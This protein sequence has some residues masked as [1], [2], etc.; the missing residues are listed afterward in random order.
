MPG[1]YDPLWL[2][3]LGI[4]PV[5]RWLHR[6][7]APLSAWPV[8]AIFLWQH[9]TQEDAPGRTKKPP[10]AV[11]R[12]R[13]LVVALLIAALANPYWKAE[14]GLLTVWV[15]DSLSMQAVENGRTRLATLLASLEGELDESGATWAEIELR[16]LSDPGR[17]RSMSGS[18]VAD[19]GDWQTG[20]LLEP[21]GP[22]GPLMSDAGSHWLLTDGASEGV[23]SWARRV[24]IERLLQTGS[25]TENSAVSHLAARRSLAIATD[26]DVLVS[27][28][29]SGLQ[30]DARRVALYSGGQLLNFSDLSLP[31]GETV[32]WQAQVAAGELPLSA[33]LSPGDVLRRDDELTLSLE[34][35]VPLA[36]VV[37]ASCGPALRRAIA[38][39]PSLRI[40]REEARPALSVSCPGDIFPAAVATAP[41][42]ARAHVRALIASPQTAVTTPVWTPYSGG[43]SNLALAGTWL[44]AAHLVEQW[45]DRA[46]GARDRILLDSADMPLVL[47]RDPG[48]G[49]AFS[50]DAVR[51]V[52]TVVDLREPL[53]ARQ[54]EY[55]A[56][57]G[58]LVDLST[59]RQLLEE[60]VSVSRD[61]RASQ[62]MPVTIDTHGSRAETQRRAADVPLSFMFILAALLLLALDTGLYAR[63]RRAAKH[64]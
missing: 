61:P 25:A 14:S 19:P 53:F 28:S 57:V 18:V 41:N 46:T 2:A 54:P 48:A 1:F 44:S 24:S 5:I 51:F 52:D 37:E 4:I 12:R 56:F 42:S 40:H 35:F 23:Q 49:P 29:N 33:R 22:P 30:N 7:Q 36:T 64:A 38:T 47:L 20:S 10:D 58:A 21:A 34:R 16:S 31:A 17:V 15:D 59:G 13:A 60:S 6:W 3:W 26:L 27:V 45:P 43:L 50:G 55:A 32:H 62:V 8:S 9:A 39:H 63:A 11:W